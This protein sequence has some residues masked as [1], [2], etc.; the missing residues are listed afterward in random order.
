MIHISMIWYTNW[1]DTI[2]IG[3][4]RYRNRNDT[5]YELVKYDIRIGTIPYTIYKSVWYHTRIGTIR[6]TN[7][8][9][10]IYE[11]VR[12]NIRIGAIQYTN[13]YDTI[14]QS[15]R[16]NI[17]IGTI[18][19]RNQYDMIYP[20]YLLKVWGELSNW[21]AELCSAAPIATKAD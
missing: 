9:N 8:Y 2:R 20:I 10:T 13:R 12:Y 16:Y 3:M 1:Y 19:R 5:K 7:Q 17:P 4:I 15:V 21:V 14:Y 11:S 6:Y 18:R